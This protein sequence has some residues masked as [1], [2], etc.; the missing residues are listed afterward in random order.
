MFENPAYILYIFCCSYCEHIERD[1]VISRKKSMLFIT[2]LSFRCLHTKR[3][4]YF[5]VWTM[6]N[7]IGRKRDQLYRHWWGW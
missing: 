6:S 3:W 5:Y 2:V 1:E 7:R 4:F